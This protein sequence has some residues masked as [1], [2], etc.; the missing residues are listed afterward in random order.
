[1]N[2]PVAAV[3]VQPPI[4]L[5]AAAKALRDHRHQHSRGILIGWMRHAREGR[6]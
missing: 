4:A 3:A 2:P 5:D 1:M 6:V